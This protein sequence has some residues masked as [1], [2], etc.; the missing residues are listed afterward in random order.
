MY[1]QLR[2]RLHVYGSDIA[3]R[4]PAVRTAPSGLKKDLF[5]TVRTLQ[6]TI[7]RSCVY[8]G[9]EGIP[10]RNRVTWIARLQGKPIS[11]LDRVTEWP[12]WSSMLGSGVFGRAR[13]CGYPD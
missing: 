12:H 13:W 11:L 2:D 5:R 6:S 7:A 8:V 3:E 9:N 1:A 10:S 4:R